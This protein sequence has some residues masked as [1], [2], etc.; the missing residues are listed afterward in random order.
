MDS[1][2]RPPDAVTDFQSFSASIATKPEAWY[3]FCRLSHEYASIVDN[4]LDYLRAECDDL[5]I[6]NTQ[7]ESDFRNATAVQEAILEKVTEN[8][9]Q[10]LQTLQDQY[11][12]ARINEALALK[13]T[14]PTVVTPDSGS[15][16]FSAENV[17]VPHD[18]TPPT[19]AQSA[20]PSTR[21]SEKIPDVEQF[22]G[23]RGQLRKFLDKIRAKLTANSDRFPSP[24]SRMIYV[25]SRLDGN[26]Y[27]QIQPFLRLEDGTPDFNDYHEILDK[28]D[29]A[30]GDPNHQENAR[31]ELMKLRQT[32]KTFSVFL[33]EF[34]RLVQES[35]ADPAYLPLMLKDAISREL[36]DMLK[37]NPPPRGCD[38][39][40]YCSHLQELENRRLEFDQKPLRIGVVMPATPVPFLRSNYRV[41]TPRFREKTPITPISGDPMDLDNVK[42]KKISE[43]GVRD[44]CSL[45]HLCF[46]CKKPGHSANNCPNKSAHAQNATRTRI[47]LVEPYFHDDEQSIAGGVEVSKN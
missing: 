5:R 47:G 20:A 22:T 33:A 10:Q 26:A 39:L 27:A 38:Y 8:S 29:A 46:Y 13:M 23:D 41:D 37:N 25:M 32:N 28:L 14:L 45:H 43:P 7:L 15:P 12:Q 6:R 44:F 34:Q 21:I 18:P 2:P 1:P 3:D 31:L 11:T 42:G 24:Q 16:K 4:R 36:R 9:R 17:P 35:R 30:F 40:A 19:P